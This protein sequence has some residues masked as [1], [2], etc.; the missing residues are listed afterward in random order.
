MT[1]GQC[2]VTP[3]PTSAVVEHHRNPKMHRFRARSL[4]PLDTVI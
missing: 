2:D 4:T 3:T 1:Y